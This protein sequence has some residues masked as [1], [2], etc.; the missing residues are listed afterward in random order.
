LR[1]LYVCYLRSTSCRHLIEVS[2]SPAAPE[3]RVRSSG[4][5]LARMRGGPAE[6]VGSA[7][8]PCCWTMFLRFATRERDA[9]HI[10]TIRSSVA[11]GVAATM[12]AARRTPRIYRGTCLLVVSIGAGLVRRN[13]RARLDAWVRIGANLLSPLDRPPL[14]AASHPSAPPRAEYRP[15]RQA[16]DRTAPSMETRSKYRSPVSTRKWALI[17]RLSADRSMSW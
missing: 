12:D 16:A 9:C 17:R 5:G 1:L 15:G 7:C 10:A 2:R 3:S 11:G 13:T 8:L 6:S 4:R 14:A